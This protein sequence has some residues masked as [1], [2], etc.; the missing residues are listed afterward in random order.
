VQAGRFYR[1][2]TT[3]LAAGVDTRLN[4]VT[5]QGH[6]LAANDDAA[7]TSLAAQL[8]WAPPAAG[9]YY[10]LVDNWSPAFGGCSAGYTVTLADIGRAFIRFMALV[11]R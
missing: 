3:G 8:T 4:I 7:P 9:T 6:V 1:L 10:A 5:G 2:S 11:G